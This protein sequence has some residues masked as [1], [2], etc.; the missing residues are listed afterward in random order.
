MHFT[1]TTISILATETVVNSAD[2]DY[3]QLTN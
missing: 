2:G 3:T 1:V